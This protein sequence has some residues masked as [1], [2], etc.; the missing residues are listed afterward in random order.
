MMIMISDKYNHYKTN[1]NNDDSTSNEP[2]Q[3]QKNV[4]G[5]TH[6]PGDHDGE[7]LHGRQQPVGICQDNIFS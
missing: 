6:D 7:P 4:E 1:N 3:R 2:R 5:K